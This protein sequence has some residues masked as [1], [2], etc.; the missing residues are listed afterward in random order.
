M[1]IVTIFGLV[2][3]VFLL[4]CQQTSVQSIKSTSDES[5]K[6]EKSQERE[7]GNSQYFKDN[8]LNPSATQECLSK[9]NVGEPFEFD[10]SINPYYLRGNF[11]GNKIVDYA[12]VIAGKKTK[13]T[14]LVICQDSKTPFVFGALANSKTPLTDMENDNFIARSWD[15]ISNEEVRSWFANDPSEINKKLTVAKGEIIEFI[16]EKD[17][18]LYI[19]WDGKNFRAIG[20]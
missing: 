18:V 12:I 1:K 8:L 13:K 9:V 17:G 10:L 16:Y 3:L 2:L 15:I 5:S 11:N 6:A 14:G 4:A 19:Y 20:E 7:T